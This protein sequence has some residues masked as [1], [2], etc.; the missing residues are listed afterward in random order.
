MRFKNEKKREEKNK[1]KQMEEIVKQC[2]KKLQS[3]KLMQDKL[4]KL[5]SAAKEQAK[6][7]RS[8]QNRVKK[9]NQYSQTILSQEAVIEKLE[10]MLSWS[11]IT[12][13]KM[14]EKLD[15]GEVMQ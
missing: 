10:E 5:Q 1:R 14:Q 13:K 7:I 9:L 15:T 11:H 12:I 4:V 3:A 6:F 2:T 8:L